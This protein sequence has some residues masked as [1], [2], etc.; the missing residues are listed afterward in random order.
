MSKL[1][2]VAVVSILAALL[3][4]GVAQPASADVLIRDA[5]A[6]DL[7]IRDDV[8]SLQQ[9]E[10]MYAAFYNPNVSINDKVAVTL[11]GE[12][13]RPI[14][15]QNMSFSQAYDFFSIQG[16]AVGPVNI[17]GD[18]LSVVGEGLIAGFPATS[19]TFYLQREGG[20]WKFDFKKF[21]ENVAC[22]GNPQ[23]DY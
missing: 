17:N 16:R 22:A 11:G 2:K 23:F 15:E 12:K 7:Y 8:P 20:L 1:I 10:R 18:S 14:V 19:A 3:G 21:C 5:K 6:A 13:A 4:L 9:L